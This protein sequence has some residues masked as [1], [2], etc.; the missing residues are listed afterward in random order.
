MLD[1]DQ[2]QA[3]YRM[4][5]AAAQSAGSGIQKYGRKGRGPA[6]DER[7]AVESHDETRIAH[8]ASAPAVGD[9]DAYDYTKQRI[10]GQ[11]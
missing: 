4:T 6:S 10:D 1:R 9:V 5:K 2:F 7:Q 3:R 8:E 11:R